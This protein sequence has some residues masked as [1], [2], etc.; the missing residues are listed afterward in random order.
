MVVCQIVRPSSWL[1]DL[2]VY[3]LCSVDSSLFGKWRVSEGGY[4]TQA[5]G[6]A[7]EGRL[8]AQRRGTPVVGRGLEASPKNHLL[9]L[10]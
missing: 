1:I 8:E 6:V 5:V 4:A 9:L 7:G 10:S 3:P 2:E